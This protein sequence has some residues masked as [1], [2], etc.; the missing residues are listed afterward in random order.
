MVWT[1]LR[2][3]WGLLVSHAKSSCRQVCIYDDM[4]GF[5]FIIL[6]ATMLTD[7]VQP[8]DVRTLECGGLRRKI[9]SSS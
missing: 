2:E 8:G 6:V 9:D 3:G 1:F 5:I 7:E 4:A